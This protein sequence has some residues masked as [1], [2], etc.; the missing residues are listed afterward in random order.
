M[1]TPL[2]PRRPSR[3]LLAV[4]AVLLAAGGLALWHALPPSPPAQAAELPQCPAIS[5]A[6]GGLAP[7]SS[8]CLFSDAADEDGAEL[9]VTSLTTEGDPVRTHY[10]RIPGRPGL[11]VLVDAS[12][13]RSG[14]GAWERQACPGATSLSHLGT[15]TSSS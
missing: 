7:T 15:C 11:E 3:V 8:S 10:R 13:D 5:V 9:V 2:T 12:D 14:S 1:T 4:T 6:Q